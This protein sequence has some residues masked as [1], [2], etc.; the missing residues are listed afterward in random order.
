M[1]VAI[2]RS[3]AIPRCAIVFCY[4][5][6]HSV[7]IVHFALR[8]GKLHDNCPATDVLW[9]VRGQRHFPPVFVCLRLVLRFRYICNARIF[10][11]DSITYSYTNMCCQ[12]ELSIFRGKYTASLTRWQSVSDSAT[13]LGNE[14]AVTSLWERRAVGNTRCWKYSALTNDSRHVNNSYRVK[15]T[16]NNCRYLLECVCVCGTAQQRSEAALQWKCSEINL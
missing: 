4:I 11:V 7:A 15:R 16:R 6:A 13:P 3:P 1:G 10:V 2:R 5:W 14:A 9:L 8:L 12:C